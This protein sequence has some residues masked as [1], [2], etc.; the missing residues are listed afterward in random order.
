[1]NVRAEAQASVGEALYAECKE[2]GLDTLLDDREERPGVKFKDADLLGIPV[3]VTIGNA[4]VKSGLVEVR[5]RGTREERKVPR[6]EVIEA[7]RALF[8][9]S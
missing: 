4:W 1:V 2:R 9:A 5:A 7:I 3:R 8:G 6:G